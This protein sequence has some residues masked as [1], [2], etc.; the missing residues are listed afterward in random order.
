MF[1]AII[2]KPPL[3]NS[4]ERE[5]GWRVGVEEHNT[6]ADLSGIFAT[7]VPKQKCF[8]SESILRATAGKR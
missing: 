8:S 7:K 4:N 5:R 1:A 3:P 6:N 2:L